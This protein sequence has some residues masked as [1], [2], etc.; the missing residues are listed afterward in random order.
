MMTTT[1]AHVFDTSVETF[2]QD[3]IDRSLQTPVL[4]DFWATW[5]GPCKALSPLLEKLAAEYNG[6]FVLAKVDVDK[7]QQLAGYS[8]IR[9]VPTLVLFKQGQIAD[10]VPGALPEGQLRQFLAQHGIEP[11]I[12]GE[13]VEVAPLSP[14]ERIATLRNAIAAA[15]AN[16]DEL[17]LDL[18]VELARLGETAEA[19][20][21]L[22][23]LPANLG[24]DDRARIGRIAI[25]YADV[26]KGAPQRD[27]LE[28]RIAANPDDSQARHWLGVR[29]LTE[30]ED[31]AAIDT[32]LD[33]LA[34][35]KAFGDGLARRAL[36]DAFST[37]A[38]AEL[39]SRSRRRMAA[40]LF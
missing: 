17:K 3:V 11:I 24:T 32:L 1:S 27:E 10:G 36:L 39:V 13:A 28:R 34:R 33:L 29:L 40:L 21:L 31:A 6:A 5:C 16:I 4:L 18:A 20:Q 7:Q 2:Q 15:P 38:D 25:G 14:A 19:Q 35:D 37:I 26:L 30:G 9:S 22:D 8:G 12:A 23:A